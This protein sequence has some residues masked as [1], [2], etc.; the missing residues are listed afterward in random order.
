MLSTGPWHK[1]A[2]GDSLQV[3]F[4]IVCAKKKGTDLERLDKPEQR[5]DLYGHL[6]WAQQTYCGEDLNGNNQLDLDEDIV[7]RGPNGLLYGADGKLTR[8]VLPTPPGQPRVHTEIDNQRVTIYWDRTSS[9]DSRD[10][11]S[12]IK[13]FEGYRV[14]RS[15]PG[16]DFVSNE[17]L[18]LSLSLV[19]DFDKPNDTVGYNTG[20][21]K[22]LIDT[23]SNFA[24]I[25][26]PGDTLDNGTPIRYFYRFPPAESEA[27]QLSGWQY[28]YGISAYDCGDATNNL[29]SLESAMT[30]RRIIA[31]TRPT[32]D[33]SREIGVYPNPYYTRAY[34]DGQG[35]RY[36]KLYFYNLPASATITIYTIAGDIVAQI[37]HNSS[38]QG[39]DIDWFQRYGDRSQPTQFSGG[40]HAWNLITK[41]DQAL[42][43]GLYLFTVKDNHTG[44]IKRGKFVVIK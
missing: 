7:T 12:G 15:K 2:P 17:N 9:E 44:T 41:Y 26:F 24:G 38:Y 32:S 13:D 30:I 25:T 23:S 21:N 37:D 8:Y 29:P 10:P 20:F 33:P 31:G 19:G 16:A 5:E 36:R 22:I 14:Y 3:V 42:A 40:E 11:I 6:H 27:T 18:L 39:E 1:L 4:T 35:E 34:W 43:T 28:I